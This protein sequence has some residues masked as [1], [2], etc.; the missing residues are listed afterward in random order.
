MIYLDKNDLT[1]QEGM[2]RAFAGYF[3]DVRKNCDGTF[4]AMLDASLESCDYE[5]KSLTLRMEL[6]GWMT[7][8]G[9]ILHGGV[10][11][12]AVDLTMGLLCR[13]Y[14]GGVMTPTVSMEVSYLKP[15]VIGG[16]LLIR[17]DLTSCGLNLCHATARAWMEDTPDRTVCT[18]AGVYYI[19]RASGGVK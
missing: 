12:S 14:G 1:S 13:Y 6:K 8:P 9:G 3:A 11:A 7:N 5:G 4:N 10:S 15:G 2:E 18:A 17:A 19:S 16:Q